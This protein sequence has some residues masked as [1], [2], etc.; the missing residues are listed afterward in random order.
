MDNLTKKSISFLL[1]ALFVLAIPPLTGLDG[2][3]ALEASAIQYRENDD[4]RFDIHSTFYTAG[5]N[6]YGQADT[7]N[8]S[9][10]EELFDQTALPSNLHAYPKEGQKYWV[11][12]NEGFR[13]N[14]LEMST[15]ETDS[16]NDG[17][18]IIWNGSL[19]PASKKGNISRCNQFYYSSSEWKYIGNYGILSDRATKVFASNVNI[20]DRSG[21]LLFKAQDKFR[22]SNDSNLNFKYCN[23]KYVSAVYNDF[24]DNSNWQTVEKI[25]IKSGSYDW[26]K[27]VIGAISANTGDALGNNIDINN[28]SAI[29]KIDLFGNTLS[30]VYGFVC[31]AREGIND[32]TMLL[33][34]NGAKRRMLLLHGTPIENTYAG[35]TLMLSDILTNAHPGDSTYF[36]HASKDADKLLRKTFSGLNGS[37]TYNLKIKFSKLSDMAD[38]PYKYSMVITESKKVYQYPIFHKGTKIE[39]I[40]SSK[41]KAKS[42]IKDITKIF[43]S[44]KIKVEDQVGTDVL[45]YLSSGVKKNSKDQTIKVNDIIY[46][47]TNGCKKFK[48]NAKAKTDISYAS[49]NKNVATVDTNGTV[50]VTGV[51][52]A[53]I[54]A[55]ATGTEK[56]NYADK[57]IKI[58][59]SPQKVTALS[60]ETISANA[61]KLIWKKVSGAKYYKIEQSTNGKT[62]KALFTTSA[63]SAIVKSLKSGTKYQFRIIAL[64]ST[65]KIASKAGSVLKT[66]TLTNAPLLSLRSAKS[67]TVVASWKKVFGASKY[68][69][70]KSTDGKKWTRE[71][72]TAKLSYTLT[73]LKRGKTIYVKIQALN[74]YKKASAYS[75]VKK[76]RVRM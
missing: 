10:P 2:I 27:A 23:Q 51:G 64:D 42:Y 49:N 4:T 47:K 3:F 76:I 22:A 58:I 11:I 45:N 63:N 70:Y 74:A 6:T 32:V 12:F 19:R 39:L 25:K 46:I 1:I 7:T 33:Q 31:G 55:V 15:F 16:T 66:C 68:V 69:V 43:N 20:Y 71:K 29:A 62:W 5:V 21:K 48:L 59:V 44:E 54:N 72:T 50:T 38:F 56:Y 9:A 73:N 65:K 37:G 35:Q 67:K 36:L 75:E 41:D 57:N 60:T 61:I 8:D 14:R 26:A 18:Y 17:A 24:E 52:T 53:I 40:Y 34:K 30:M 13:N 28:S